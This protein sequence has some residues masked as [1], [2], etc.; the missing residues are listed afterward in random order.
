M[1]KHQDVYYVDIIPSA[2]Y[3]QDKIFP[4]NTVQEPEHLRSFLTA[5]GWSFPQQNFF[6]GNLNK[7]PIRFFICDDSG[8]MVIQDGE[9]FIMS[10]RKGYR[11]TCTRWDELCETLKFQMTACSRGVIRSKF[12]FLNGGTFDVTNESDNESEMLNY[13]RR[14][15]EG[16]TPLC[17]TLYNVIDEIKT[18]EDELRSSN[19][20]AEII[21]ATDGESSDGDIR[22]PLLKLKNLPV[23]LVLRLC[24]DKKRIVDYW[25]SIDKDLE[26]SLDVL[27]GYY[28]EA[29]E[30]YKNNSWLCYSLSIHSMR[31]F[32]VSSHIFDRIDEAPLTRDEKIGVLEILYGEI[33]GESKDLDGEIK[34]KQLPKRFCPIE[35]RTREWVRFSSDRCVIC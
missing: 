31:E 6:I 14:V 29:K 16:G 27:D 28:N 4:T 26:L 3:E 23:K 20:F 18:I 12:I 22:I 13:L 11:T 17:R 24:T 32:G 7:I 10:N 21:I 2:P 19:R 9:K 1:N 25:N 35:N 34:K 15:P 8:S 30:V 5:N 33:D